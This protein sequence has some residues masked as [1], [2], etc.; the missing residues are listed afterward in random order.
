MLTWLWNFGDGSSS[1]SSQPGSHIFNGDGTFHVSLTVTDTM[2][3]TDTYTDSIVVNDIFTFYIPN[4]FTPNGDGTNDVFLPKGLMVDANHYQM[5]IIPV[6]ELWYS[7]Q[8]MLMK[9]G[10]EP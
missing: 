4:T 2:G 8:R 3:C 5:E 1:S 7:P 6:G 10:M 9:A